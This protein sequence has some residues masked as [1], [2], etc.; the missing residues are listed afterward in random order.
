MFSK[1]RNLVVFKYYCF[2]FAILFFCQFRLEIA[3]SNRTMTQTSEKTNDFAKKMKKYTIRNCWLSLQKT[4][5]KLFENF[6]HE[7][8]AF[9]LKS[10]EI[11]IVSNAK[12]RCR[13][14]YDKRMNSK[15]CDTIVVWISK[16][17]IQYCI[18]IE[19][20]KT[21]MFAKNRRISHH[22]L[23]FYNNEILWKSCSS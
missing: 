10:H 23:K 13:R 4:L 7:I 17:K 2:F 5:T 6:Q 8:F 19:C 15:L 12:N 9:I 3:V 11:V 1:S 21:K 22:F 18:S 20:K 16:I 14:R